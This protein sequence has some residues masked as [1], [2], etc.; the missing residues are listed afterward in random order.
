V[1]LLLI[2]ALGWGLFLVRG[3]GASKVS[4]E[5]YW[6]YVMLALLCLLFA[7][8]GAGRW[9]TFAMVYPLRWSAA[10]SS[11]RRSGRSAV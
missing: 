8:A 9:A 4:H 6:T 3:P 7:L 10:T 11:R 1:V 2:L 5:W